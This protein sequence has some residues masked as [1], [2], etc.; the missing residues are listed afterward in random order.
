M[1][2][3]WPL[4]PSLSATAVQQGG[5]AW[6]VAYRSAS[7]YEAPGRRLGFKVGPNQEINRGFWHPN[8]AINPIV[9]QYQFFQAI[10]Y[11][12]VITPF[13]TIVGAHLVGFDSTARDFFES[14]KILIF[15]GESGI[16][17]RVRGIN[18]HSSHGTD[19]FPY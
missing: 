8:K 3:R 1:V 18:T 12:R 6:Q 9:T 15:R 5:E 19:I 10:Y 2:A 16:V 13:I 4:P 14:E 11:L 17:F 7:Y